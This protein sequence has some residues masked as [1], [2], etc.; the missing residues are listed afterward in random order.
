MNSAVAQ[1]GGFGG[2]NF[3]NMG[4]NGAGGFHNGHDGMGWSTGWNGQNNMGFNPGMEGTRNGGYYSAASAGG[5]NH[6]SHGNLQMPTQQYQNHHFQRQQPYLRG[7]R[8]FVGGARQYSHERQQQQAFQDAQFSQQLQGIDEAVAAV[9]GSSSDEKK[10]EKIPSVMSGD[11]ENIADP[12]D[13]PTDTASTV[14][15][16][17]DPATEELADPLNP[18]VPV[19][20]DMAQYFPTDDFRGPNYQMPFYPARGNFRGS[21]RGGYRGDFGVGPRG[22][23]IHNVA[24]IPSVLGDQDSDKIPSVGLGV[25]G[26]PTGPKALREGIPPTRGIP[27]RA[28]SRGRGGYTGSSWTRRFV[29]FYIYSQMLGRYSYNLRFSISPG[30]VRTYSRSRSRRRSSATGRDRSRDPSHDHRRKSRS[31]N[32]DRSRHRKQRSPSIGSD[33]ERRGRTPKRDSEEPISPLQDK[34]LINIVIGEP[35]D[36]DVTQPTS[37]IRSKRSREDS[38]SRERARSTSRSRSRSADRHHKRSR[39]DRERRI[40]PIAES[41]DREGRDRDREGRDRE[42]RDKD[43][44][45]KESRDKESRDKDG[46]SH[47]HRRSHKHKSS[48]RHHSRSRSRSPKKDD[49]PAEDKATVRDIDEADGRSRRDSRERERKHKR[50]SKREESHHRSHRHKSSRH[51]RHNRHD[52]DDK[53][54]RDEKHDR[55]EKYDRKDDRKDKHEKGELDAIAEKKTE[56]QRHAE[57]DSDRK[58]TRDSRSRR[59]PSYKYEDEEDLERRAERD[60][61]AE[62]WGG[63]KR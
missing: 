17:A 36:T 44:R 55:E 39:R 27:I 9:V 23:G 20:P 35:N 40:G 53:H 50:R 8:G 22:G 6:Q 56:V 32:R 30:H 14:L 33:G 61:E 42:G 45:D 10:G 58:S 2:G 12:N 7:G 15:T 41:R 46:S 54:D 24:P 26:A 16:G 38:G 28:F 47:H 1:G 59:K 31:R 43:S 3:G 37:A 48:R 51:D 62:R 5:Y 52:K 29:Q 25:E 60:R 13:V 63:V 19:N 34:E 4:M 11:P 57:K 21:F 18:A 49:Y